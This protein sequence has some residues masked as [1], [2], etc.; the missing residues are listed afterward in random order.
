[1]LCPRHARRVMSPHGS[2]LR[3]VAPRRAAPRRTAPRLHRQASR[4]P[5]FCPPELRHERHVPKRKRLTTRRISMVGMAENFSPRP[6]TQNYGPEI[7]SL[8]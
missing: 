4:G 2:D 7:V 5:N 3:R 8:K 1:M 6:V